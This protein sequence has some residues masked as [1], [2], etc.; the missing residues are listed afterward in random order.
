MSDYC[1]EP[2]RWDTLNLGN[3]GALVAPRRAALVIRGGS[4]WPGDAMTG[5]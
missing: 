5:A 2:T 4:L 3:W 1:G